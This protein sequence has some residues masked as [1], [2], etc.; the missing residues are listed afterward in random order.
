[1][2]PPRLGE[3]VLDASEGNPFFVEELLASLIDQGVLE[4]ANGGWRGHKLPESFAVPDSVQSLVAAR[5]DLLR[6]AE[7][8]ALQAASV[9]GRVFWAGP[10]AELVEEAGVDFGRLEERDFIHRRPRSSISGE[11]EFAFKHTLTRE[12]AYASL[13]RARRA[14]LH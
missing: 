7:K 4:R 13:P 2:L 14:R 5:L 10:V 8:A 11:H 9:V 1:E 6:P 3:L 12:V